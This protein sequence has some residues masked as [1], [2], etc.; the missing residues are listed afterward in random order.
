M[1]TYDGI[2]FINKMIPKMGDLYKEAIPKRGDCNKKMKK[3]IMTM[4]IDRISTKFQL[5]YSPY[6]LEG[7]QIFL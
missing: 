1:S 3:S 5:Y 4:E 7:P 2:D 6:V